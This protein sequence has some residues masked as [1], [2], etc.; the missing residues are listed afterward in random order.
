S[1]TINYSG[2]SQDVLR[3]QTR[4]GGK[5]VKLG[6]FSFSS[7]S[8]A[9]VTLTHT[10]TAASAADAIKFISSSNEKNRGYVWRAAVAM[11]KLSQA[12]VE[13]LADRVSQNA[14]LSG[15]TNNASIAFCAP[16]KPALPCERFDF[17]KFESVLVDNVNYDR[18]TATVRKSDLVDYL[19][20]SD[21]PAQAARY[22]TKNGV[23]DTVKGWGSYGDYVSGGA[24]PDFSFPYRIGPFASLYRWRFPWESYK[25]LFDER[26]GYSGFGPYEAL[27][28]DVLNNFG[29]GGWFWSSRWTGNI[30]KTSRFA[31]HLRTLSKIKLAMMFKRGRGDSNPAQL[32]VQYSDEWITDYDAAVEYYNKEQKEFSDKLS[33]YQQALKDAQQN[34]TTAPDAPVLNSKI[35]TTR[36][37][38][39]IVKS[40]IPWDSPDWMNPSAYDASTPTNTFVPERW[41]SWQLPSGKG[42]Y[43]KASAYPLHR[44]IRDLKGWRPM[45]YTSYN[46]DTS[47]SAWTEGRWY[48]VASRVW[49]KKWK[50]QA[51]Y[52]R[53]DQLN[54][55]I[56]YQDPDNPTSGT[57]PYT[58]YYFQ[59][60]VFGGIE[61]RNEIMVSDPLD[62]ASPDDLPAPILLDSDKCE[63]NSTGEQAN[64]SSYLRF[65]G[66]ASRSAPARVWPGQFTL[67]NPAGRMTAV[68]EAVVFNNSSWDLWTQDW[69]AQLVPV[70]G[71]EDWQNTL[72]TQLDGLNDVDTQE[73]PD[74]VRQTLEYLLSLDP[75]FMDLYLDH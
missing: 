46:S 18:D 51:S 55:P 25:Q 22:K 61:L 11:D 53:Y 36:Y 67:G 60:R 2:G 63:Y 52:D 57:I 17:S 23:R 47:P 44:W 34:N 45:T 14:N 75:Q 31:F 62:G 4:N 59:I 32:P 28:R 43:T 40:T 37:Y 21:D 1:Y 73:N 69:R 9:Q 66:V 6:E 5:W 33:E 49:A 68:A 16:L 15:E 54:L 29:Q 39:V 27:L 65:L 19:Y 50:T 24:I 58:I 7:D 70:S 74:D 30:S 72:A 12:T 26:L 13:N 38:D 48:E 8:P 20:N 64:H 35:M 56:R 3:D 42:P 10:G 41:F 71:W